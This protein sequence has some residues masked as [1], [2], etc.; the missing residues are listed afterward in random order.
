MAESGDLETR[1]K[2]TEKMTFAMEPS[3]K[4]RL[5]RKADECNTQPSK[6]LRDL[7]AWYLGS[8]TPNGPSVDQPPA[9]FFGEVQSL[10]Q[11]AASRLGTTPELLVRRMVLELLDSYLNEIQQ[12]SD[13][14]EVLRKKLEGK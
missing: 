13:R 10:L 9:L 8:Y 3:L 2:V 4:N 11:Q 14:L 5:F 1:E 12:D 7:V 6:V